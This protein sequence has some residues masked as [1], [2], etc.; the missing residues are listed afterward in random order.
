MFFKLNISGEKAD[1][2]SYIISKHPDSVFEREVHKRGKIIARFEQYTQ[3]RAV[4]GGYLENYSLPFLRLCREENKNSYVNAEQYA[5]C[6]YNLELL[7]ITFRSAM[8]GQF[9]NISEED[10]YRE[11][12]IDLIIGP[13][14]LYKMDFLKEVIFNL[15]YVV[16]TWGFNNSNDTAEVMNIHGKSDLCHFLQQIY[17]IF[18][19][20]TNHLR[21]RVPMKQDIEK[22]ITLSKDWIDKHPDRDYIRNR[23][24]KVRRNIKTFESKLLEAGGVEEEKIKDSVEEK[25]KSMKN[26]AS[27][28]RYQIIT[29][30]IN[31]GD[32]IL[33]F[34][35]ASGNLINRILKVKTPKKL[36]GF[37]ANKRCI[38]TAYKRGKDQLRW[39]K[40]KETEFKTYTGSILYPDYSLFEGINVVV[41]AEVL[42]HFNKDEISTV[43]D[44][45]FKGISPEK[46]ILTTPN[47]DY[48]V[49]FENLRE[50]GL[51]HPDHQFE[52]TKEEIIQ[53]VSDIQFKYGY[54][55]RFCRMDNP[56][57][58]SYRRTELSPF[59]QISHIIYLEK[60]QNSTKDAKFVKSNEFLFMPFDLDMGA[61]RVSQKTIREG[62][63]T[64]NHKVDPRWIVNLTP[65]MSP[66][67]SSKL[68][69]YIEHPYDAL[70]YYRAR[71]VP[72]VIIE[73]KYMGSNAHIVA[74]RERDISEK[75]FGSKDL[76]S[77]YS[78]KGYRFFDNTQIEEQIYEELRVFM[79]L[80]SCDVIA[81]NTEI[82]PWSYKAGTMIDKEFSIPGWCAYVDK[83]YTG[84]SVD[85]EFLYLQSLAN[86]IK[87]SDIRIH[88]F[89]IV[90]A[91]VFQNGKFRNALNGYYT[92]HD[93]QL[94]IMNDN[95]CITDLFRPVDYM[96]YSFSGGQDIE[97]VVNYW[98]RLERDGLEG[99]VIKPRYPTRFLINGRYVQP[100]LKCRTREYLRIIYGI[101]YLEPD[102]L[103]F[104]K[105]RGTAQKRKLAMQQFELSQKILYSF[106]NMNHNQRLKYLFSY[107]GMEKS[108]II[109]NTL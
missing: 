51:R 6:P 73:T 49:N 109:D 86:Y 41:L 4:Y 81:L 44:I 93:D 99:V 38:N 48:N 89:N 35:C 70:D 65:N 85:K 11:Y 54:S 20:Y 106:L 16:S 91:S 76:I 95:L 68:K 9:E 10:F 61:F 15:G 50:N 7:N 84:R 33:D 25:M 92:N 72:E 27:E 66:A 31:S 64:F 74:T 103:Q 13:F 8:R 90:L 18:Y 14:S 1:L 19:A 58:G 105:R 100:A 82:L 34:G 79:D 97:E 24:A 80:L 57:G 46:V 22:Y 2:V 108:A 59:D 98:G 37:D 55:Y 94:S 69:D 36:I 102:N 17:V 107:F 87:S 71:D 83:I 47:K 77:I 75:L 53:L 23:L 43:L 101:D 60:T 21:F 104:L 29:S 3:D 78:R 32:S 26:K 96:L 45:I 30:L 5:I 88:P 28:R 67:D 56:D 52:F 40:N 12:D 62:S 63:G 42:E 39:T